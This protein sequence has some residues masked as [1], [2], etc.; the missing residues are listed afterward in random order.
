MNVDE[1]ISASANIPMKLLAIIK[2]VRY[3]VNDRGEVGLSFGVYL[4]EEFGAPQFLHPAWAA[5]VV[6]QY[7]VGDV[8][9][10]EG[11]PCWVRVSGARQ[12]VF[13]SPCLI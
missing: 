5:V 4:S 12:C 8:S 13:E 3:G 11:K 1:L 2:G 7:G 9:R 10:L 6:K